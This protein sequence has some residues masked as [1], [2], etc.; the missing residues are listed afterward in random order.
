M[1]FHIAFIRHIL[2]K[3]SNLWEVNAA[4]NG[5]KRIK[6]QEKDWDGQIGLSSYMVGVGKVDMFGMGNGNY[7]GRIGLVY[8]PKTKMLVGGKGDLGSGVLDRKFAKE[9]N[10]YSRAILEKGPRRESIIANA[11]V[12]VMKSDEYNPLGN[13]LILDV[14]EFVAKMLEKA[15]RKLEPYDDAVSK[16]VL[17][18]LL[19]KYVP[20]FSPDNVQPFSLYKSDLLEA[21]ND[22]D[23]TREANSVQHALIKLDR[24]SEDE[25][26][27]YLKRGLEF[28]NDYRT[29]DGQFKYSLNANG[30]LLND[31]RMYKELY[32]GNS[33]QHSLK[34]EPSRYNECLIAPVEGNEGAGAV[35]IILIDSDKEAWDAA[36]ELNKSFHEQTNRSLPYVKYDP[37]EGKIHHILPPSLE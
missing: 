1:G 26:I 37:T 30:Q 10:A 11:I 22:K 4:T 17:V 29:E 24:M 2:G 28:N 5:G 18:N 32:A 31:S 14:H 13:H 12:E 34:D 27:E 15:L 25:Q 7:L 21:L 16:S 8:G 9:N 19:T 6:E 3:T 36:K 35:G 23:K 20:Q 33:D